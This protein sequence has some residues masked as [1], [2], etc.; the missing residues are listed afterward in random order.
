MKSP[1]NAPTPLF[2][3]LWVTLPSPVGTGTSVILED[4][5]ELSS[6]QNTSTLSSLK[7]TLIAQL[8]SRQAW[9]A[10]DIIAK[11]MTALSHVLMNAREVLLGYDFLSRR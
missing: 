7:Y 3:R 6:P 10:R 1:W 5:T 8:R 2:G 11:D 4:T 9:E